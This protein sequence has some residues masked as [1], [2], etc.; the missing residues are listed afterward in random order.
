MTETVKGT[1]T[2]KSRKGTGIQINKGQWLNAPKD[3][4]TL[5]DGINYKD[6]VEAEVNGTEVVSIK[7]AGGTSASQNSAPANNNVDWDARQASIEWQSARN[8]AAPV[9]LAI[10]EQ[11]LVPM[12]GAKEAKYDATM[13]LIYKTATKFYQWSIPSKTPEENV[14]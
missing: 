2:S 5:F 9:V 13:D 4:Q 11:G 3:N 1:I 6:E 10:I 8:A 12:A 14:D 7:K